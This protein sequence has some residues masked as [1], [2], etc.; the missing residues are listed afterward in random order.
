MAINKVLSILD[1]NNAEVMKIYA[2]NFTS[3]LMGKDTLT[4]E[5]SLPIQY[6]ANNVEIPYSFSTQWHVDYNNDVFYLNSDNPTGVKDN[7]NRR[8]RYTLVFESYRNSLDNI[9]IKPYGKVYR[10]EN[11]D[12]F[13]DDSEVTSDI[14]LGESVGFYG[15][16][17]DFV[18]WLRKNLEVIYGYITDATGNNVTFGSDNHLALKCTAILNKVAYSDVSSLDAVYTD[19]FNDENSS[20]P[21]YVVSNRQN[22]EGTEQTFSAVL[23]TMNEVFTYKQVLNG[24]EKTI[25]YTYS[26]EKRNIEGTEYS[27]YVIIID[28]TSEVVKNKYGRDVIFEYGGLTKGG[29]LLSITRTTQDNKLPTRIYGKGSTDN[30]PVNYFYIK[31]DRSEEI[32]MLLKTGGYSRKI[33]N[34]QELETYYASSPDDIDK[35]KDYLVPNDEFPFVYDKWFYVGGNRRLAHVNY[36]NNNLSVVA[37]STIRKVD[38]FSDD[39]NYYIIDNQSVRCQSGW[40]YLKFEGDTQWNAYIYDEINNELTDIGIWS[41]NNLGDE[42]NSDTGLPVVGHDFLASGTIQN[43]EHSELLILVNGKENKPDSLLSNKIYYVI[44]KNM[45]NTFSYYADCEASSYLVSGWINSEETTYERVNPFT[46]YISNVQNLMPDFMRSYIAGWRYGLIFAQMSNNNS[47]YNIS[48]DYVINKDYADDWDNVQVSLLQNGYRTIFIKNDMYPLAFIPLYRGSVFVDW[49]FIGILETDENN[50]YYNKDIFDKGLSDFCIGITLNIQTHKWNYSKCGKIYRPTDYYENS[51]LVKKYGV[52]EARQDF[53]DIK[54]TITGVWYNGVGRLDELVGVYVPC[55]DADS[56]ET[57][58]GDS[59]KWGK[60]WLDSAFI[61]EE[62]SEYTDVSGVTH[63]YVSHR[64]NRRVPDLYVPLNR[65]KYVIEFSNGGLG[66]DYFPYLYKNLGPSEVQSVFVPIDREWFAKHSDVFIGLS[67]RLGEYK[68]S[69]NDFILNGEK[70][71]DEVIPCPMKYILLKNFK[72]EI[73]NAETGNRIA[74]GISNGRINNI[75]TFI[76]YEVTVKTKFSNS[77]ETLEFYPIIDAKMG[78]IVLTSFQDAYVCTNV[79][80]INSQEFRIEMVFFSSSAVSLNNFGLLTTTFDPTQKNGWHKYR[81]TV[82]RVPNNPNTQTI[83]HLDEIGSGYT[84]EYTQEVNVIKTHTQNNYNYPNEFSMQTNNSYMG[85]NVNIRGVDNIFSDMALIDMGTTTSD[86]DIKKKVYSWHPAAWKY[87][88]NTGC[89]FF[90]V[91]L[92]YCNIEIETNDLFDYTTREFFVYTKDIK[93]SPSLPAFQGEEYPALV[94][95]TGDL[96]GIENKFAFSEI[97]QHGTEPF[98]ALDNDNT[99]IEAITDESGV[100]TYES[101]VPYIHT[102][103]TENGVLADVPAKYRASLRFILPDTADNQSVFNYLP[104]RNIKPK[105]KDLFILENVLYPHNPYVYEAERRLGKALRDALDIEARYTYTIVFDDIR[106]ENLGIDYN[107]LR[108]GN[109]IQVKNNSLVTTLLERFATFEIKTVS[110]QKTE[111][112]LYDRYTLVLKNYTKQKWTPT[113]PRRGDDRGLDNGFFNGNI[114]NRDSIINQAIDLRLKNTRRDLRNIIS[115]ES[116]NITNN[117]TTN[118]VRTNTSITQINDNLSN[119]HID[120]LDKATYRIVE[121]IPDIKEVTDNKVVYFVPSLT[122]QGVRMKAYVRSEDEIVEVGTDTD[123]S[124]LL[125]SK[126]YD[127]TNAELDKDIRADNIDYDHTLGM[128]R[129]IGKVSIQ[130]PRKSTYSL[131]LTLYDNIKEGNIIANNIKY[132]IQTSMM[133]PFK[134]VEVIEFEADT[135]IWL[136]S[137]SVIETTFPNIPTRLSQLENDQRFIASAVQQSTLVLEIKEKQE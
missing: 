121:K 22:I 103:L 50:E 39:G 9:F 92:E 28:P 10:D 123:L 53:N 57:D 3:E 55:L 94:F 61:M 37:S 130:V 93:F 115:R 11:N 95:N 62:T 23:Q 72:Y 48:G 8:I 89:K 114:I 69:K 41:D 65:E 136:Q 133:I 52:I 58:K 102:E 45:D 134:S 49:E 5:V 68:F 36:G 88:S 129:L 43:V 75:A 91:G 73:L 82:V 71:F 31:E 47:E 104:Q 66:E 99:P 101:R 67:I 20:T 125:Y 26:F 81:Y 79:C 97:I 119:V 83:I 117:I 77:E 107:Q 124:D 46:K 106:R 42:F 38:G 32:W 25:G 85:L 59:S 116:N 76:K 34:I 80:I 131:S 60:Y 98:V 105:A 2:Y 35:T 70:H 54:P 16:L 84:L 7:E 33:K 109:K 122:K 1:E 21:S 128:F 127:M 14:L 19:E 4:M 63:E 113:R 100:T 15:N 64:Y 24:K 90:P 126:T 120:L 87:L 29:G 6:D 137:I 112:N 132:P 51:E 108:V 13:A 17:Y 118:N 111:D 56:D 135:Y 30:L 110:I 96:Q 12:G 44:S 27:Y 74:G 86:S 78:S 40:I 18:K